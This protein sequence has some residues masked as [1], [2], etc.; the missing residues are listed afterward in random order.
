MKLLFRFISHVKTK[1]TPERPDGNKRAVQIASYSIASAVSIARFTGGK[2][3]L[4][5]VL[6][7]SALG[8]RIE[9]FVY[10]AHHRQSGQL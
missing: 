1:L 6:V 7:G 8:Y 10:S 3:Y 9:T 2:H 5:D 4:S